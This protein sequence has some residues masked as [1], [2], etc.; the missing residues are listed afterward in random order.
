MSTLKLDKGS[1]SQRD[2]ARGERIALWYLRF[3]GYRLLEQNYL[4]GHKEIDLIVRKGS[5]VAFVEVKAR[6]S[7]EGMRP[8]DSVD[9]RKRKNI[10]EASRYY[11][12]RSE[13]YDVAFRYDVIE[14]DL[15]TV[16]VTHIINA[17][18]ANF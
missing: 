18:Y 13:L 8:M 16:K 1:K 5:T 4:V 3:H 10:I 11:I 2:G 12:A 14:V 15:K 17:Y 9:F 6:R 7:I